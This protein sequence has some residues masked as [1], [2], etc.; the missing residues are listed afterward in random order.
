MVMLTGEIGTGKTTLFR[1]IQRQ[2]SDK[3]IYAEIGNPFLSPMEQVS[4][5]CKS[6]G[7]KPPQSLRQGIAALTA[8]FS[9]KHK[10]GKQ[11][12]LIF[13]ETHLLTKSHWGQILVF[14]N[15]R[16]DDE[17]IVQI[18][19]VG[20]TELVDRLMEPGLEALNQRIGIR[21]ELSP[22]SLDDTRKYVRFKLR[23]SGGE[24]LEFTN[25]ALTEVWKLSGGVP[26]LINH[27]CSH[28]LDQIVFSGGKKVTPAMVKQLAADGMYTNLFDSKPKRKRNL[29][30]PSMPVLAVLALLL[31]GYSVYAYY[32][33]LQAYFRPAEEKQIVSNELRG[34]V[35]GVS[36]GLKSS[37]AES[38]VST[39]AEGRTDEVPA[40]VSPAVP[41]EMKSS[42]TKEQFAAAENVSVS[43][44]KVPGNGSVASVDVPQVVD[45][46]SNGTETVVNVKGGQIEAAVVKPVD[47]RQPVATKE[48]KAA[49]VVPVI[50]AKKGTDVTTPKKPA[51]PQNAT[52]DKLAKQA[53]DKVRKSERGRKANVTK[54]VQAQ[55]TKESV[56]NTDLVISLKRNSASAPLKPVKKS[57]Q[58]AKN[59]K[60]KQLENA[61][62]AAV[63]AS[64]SKDA[65]KPASKEISGKILDGALTP[66]IAAIEIGAV[67]YSETPEDSLAV[68]NQ[69]LMRK[70]DVIGNLR[71]VHIGKEEL[72]FVLGGNKYRRVFGDRTENNN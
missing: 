46:G 27:A 71:L 30:M 50:E 69:Q 24:D 12:V 17:P 34:N 26:R 8:F 21:C 11:V 39:Q 20:Q 3:F 48:K 31:C 70:G 28:L 40:S 65:S 18:L 22:L 19:L 60:V 64:A 42:E 35:V 33:D 10:E 41:A 49:L 72:I 44:P 67:A 54:P 68:L 57:G 38:T 52:L 32:D 62:A 25:R 55:A 15:L 6:F 66:E 51:A 37:V 2:K 23:A 5:F 59:P 43:A 13:D 7:L 16:E 4:H 47:Q 14:S 53:A 56:K 1:F 63:K 9:A 61:K 58:A 29:S 45:S 36:E